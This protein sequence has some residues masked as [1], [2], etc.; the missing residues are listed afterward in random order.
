M[1]DSLGN[2]GNGTDKI[3]ARLSDLNDRNLEVIQVE[4]ER[5]LRLFKS[6]ETL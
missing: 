2:H 3:E 5:K 1:K 6:E 4:E